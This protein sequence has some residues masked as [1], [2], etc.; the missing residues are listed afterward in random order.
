MRIF[1]GNLPRNCEV[2]DLEIWFLALGF[3]TD[4]ATVIRDPITKNSRGFGFVEIDVRSL[5]EIQE[6]VADSTLRG[7]TLTLGIAR[8]KSPKHEADRGIVW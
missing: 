2:C 7:R 4:K 8:P 1:V 3:N 6:K 5:E